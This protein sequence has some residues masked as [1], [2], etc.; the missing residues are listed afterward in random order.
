MAK[1][2]NFSHWQPSLSTQPRT[3]RPAIR[4]HH[5]RR[6]RQDGSDE[7]GARASFSD[8]ELLPTDIWILIF[9]AA[10]SGEETST[11]DMPTMLAISHVSRSWRRLTLHLPSLWTRVYIPIRPTFQHWPPS[12]LDLQLARSQGLPLDVTLDS[13]FSAK[14]EELYRAWLP[15]WTREVPER[16]RE[17]LLQLAP[18]VCRLRSFVFHMAQERVSTLPLTEDHLSSL[19]MVVPRSLCDSWR[20][21]DNLVDVSLIRYDYSREGLTIVWPTRTTRLRSLHLHHVHVQWAPLAL[22]SLCE[23]DLRG[24]VSAKDRTSNSCMTYSEL[25]AALGP[26]PAL[27]SLTLTSLAV[28]VQGRNLS[29]GIHRPNLSHLRALRLDGTCHAT[30]ILEFLD[31]PDI[32]SIAV[33]DG[34]A[35][36]VVWE[37]L[38]F[39]AEDR[40]RRFARVEHLWLTSTYPASGFPVGLAAALPSLR[41]ATFYGLAAAHVRHSLIEVDTQ[42]GSAVVWH[43]LRVLTLSMRHLGDSSD[44]AVDYVRG[45]VET[46]ALAGSPLSELKLLDEDGS[47]ISRELVDWLGARLSFQNLSEPVLG[48]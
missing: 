36:S 39:V 38:K 26:T 35:T 11:T 9:S 23:L 48:D 3:P 22:A 25:S 8:L 19:D 12:M 14:D 6:G 28:G 40:E 17:V 27:Q 31:A 34:K 7:C 30:H 33:E 1:H 18:H 47:R 13:K 41:R 5:R 10:M 15:Y 42:T 46:R 2:S 21:L 44:A 37:V 20:A 16:Y 24:P 4:K 43:C 32:R 29:A 45:L